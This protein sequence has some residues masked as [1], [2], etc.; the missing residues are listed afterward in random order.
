VDGL[1][2]A[3][4]EWVDGLWPQLKQQLAACLSDGKPQVHDHQTLASVWL[5]FLTSCQAVQ[6][7][8]GG[9]CSSRECLHV[10]LHTIIPR[11]P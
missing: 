3:I 7:T 9:G 1:E 2:D 10:G 4:D 5:H 6:V 8:Q 11:A